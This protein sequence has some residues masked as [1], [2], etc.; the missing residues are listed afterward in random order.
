MSEKVCQSI[1]STSLIP[2]VLLAMMIVF[3][4]SSI[5]ADSIY[6]DP[7]QPSFTLL[8][9]D[10]WTAQ[11]NDQGV[12][13][14]RGASYFMLRV[15]GGNS[16]PG[17]ILVQIRPQFEQQWKQFR[18]LEAGPIKFG[19]Q[20]GAYAVYAGIPPSGISSI[21]K[22]VTMTNGQLTYIAFEGMQASVIQQHKPDMDRIERS[23]LPDEIR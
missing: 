3:S 8:V 10:G 21:T 16:S 23:F 7:R 6:R 9:P 11:P 12:Q 5:A 2:L 22:V 15:L 19:G 20:N 18:E 1:Q 4:T 17:S 14:K 13:L